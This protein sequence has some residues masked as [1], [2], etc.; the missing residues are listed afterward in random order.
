[1]PHKLNIH[2]CNFPFFLYLLLS[3]R[4]ILFF[5]SKQYFSEPFVRLD[6]VLLASV[7]WQDM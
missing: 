5:Y 7:C 2:H 3:A 6:T 1:M 4:L